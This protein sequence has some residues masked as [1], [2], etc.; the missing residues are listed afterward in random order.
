MQPG[1]AG[2]GEHFLWLGTLTAQAPQ[3]PRHLLFAPVADASAVS[4][5][6]RT[7]SI[8]VRGARVSNGHD[9][10]IVWEAILTDP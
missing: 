9:V 10:L 1:R 3:Q 4:A 5:T 7:P 8:V 6:H 2:A